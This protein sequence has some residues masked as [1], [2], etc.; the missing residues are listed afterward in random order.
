[1]WPVELRAGLIGA[2]V[3]MLAWFAP[4]LVGGGD[5]ITQQTLSGAEALSTVPVTFLLRFG[6]G[7]VDLS[8]LAPSRRG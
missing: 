5:T 6:L 2:A 1:M 4:G 8:R 3:G 7:A